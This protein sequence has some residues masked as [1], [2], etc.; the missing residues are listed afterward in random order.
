MQP[1]QPPTLSKGLRGV[2]SRFFHHRPPGVVVVRRI[3]GGPGLRG[4]SLTP[5]PSQ[6][7]S[8]RSR[9]SS[10]SLHPSCPLCFITKS[11]KMVQFGAK[12]SVIK[13]LVLSSMENSVVSYILDIFCCYILYMHLLLYF[14]YAHT[15]KDPS[16][17]R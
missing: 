10:S 14:I 1:T 11:I 8:L 5:R 4:W 12:F 16:P 9:V 15:Y 6:P 17:P 7:P 13:G 2:L 3:L